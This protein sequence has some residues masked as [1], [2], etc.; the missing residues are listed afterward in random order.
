M[1]VGLVLEEIANP[2]MKRTSSVY[3][4]FRSLDSSYVEEVFRSMDD[5]QR[6]GV[7]GVSSGGG[8]SRGTGLEA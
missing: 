4:L 8:Q 5:Y 2:R 3:K 7:E 1:R 6:I